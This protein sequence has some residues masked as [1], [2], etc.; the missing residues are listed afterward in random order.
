LIAS[1][2]WIAAIFLRASKTACRGD[3][4]RF[5]H[6]RTV[7]VAVL[8]RTAFFSS[9]EVDDPNL[10][11]DGRILDTDV[12]QETAHL[13]LRQ[14]AGAFLLDR[15][16]RRHHHEQGQ[17]AVLPA[18]NRY[19][20]FLY[21]LKHG[22]LQFG[23]RTIDLVAGHDVGEDRTRLEANLTRA[24]GL[25]V[26]PGTGHVGPQEV[27]RELD[28]AEVRLEVFR[29][30]P[31]LPRPGESGQALDEQVAIGEQADDQAL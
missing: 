13:C 5:L 28:A 17:H 8:A 3:T 29:E 15:V 21:R 16:L 26:H 7:T 10:V 25:V 27:R 22:G 30:R 4:C 1:E 2:T 18:G 9:H 12:H 31:D 24:V 20:A 14:R 19:L 23:G 6:R 11:F